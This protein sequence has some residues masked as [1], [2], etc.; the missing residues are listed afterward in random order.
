MSGEFLQG[1]RNSG[2]SEAVLLNRRSKNIVIGFLK[3]PSLTLTCR[4]VH[5]VLEAPTDGDLYS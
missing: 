3:S 5:V 2:S 1:S 4:Q